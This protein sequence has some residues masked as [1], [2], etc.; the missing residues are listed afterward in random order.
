[1]EIRKIQ[2]TDGPGL[3]KF[4]E[5]SGTHFHQIDPLF[6]YHGVESDIVAEILRYAGEV[7]VALE[8]G[9]IIGLLTAK[10]RDWDTKHF[11]YSVASIDHFYTKDQQ[12]AESLLTEFSNWANQEKIAFSSIKTFFKS[13]ITAAL[14]KSG[15]YFVEE[16]SYLSKKLP[17]EKLATIEG[18]F[19]AGFKLRDFEPSDLDEL[20]R[21]VQATEWSNRFHNDS[22]IDKTKANEVYT[23]W[24]KNGVAKQNTRV[25]ILEGN[26]KIAGFILWSIS[27]M[28]LAASAKATAAEVGDQE[29]VAMAPEFRGQGLGKFL[30]GGCVKQMQEAGCVLVW[31]VVASQNLAAIKNLE[32]LGFTAPYKVSAYHWFRK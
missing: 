8:L 19:P 4:L 24:V 23:N 12:I 28:G 9:K 22:K 5:K 15:F 25:T 29:M 27:K 10:K 13:E 31:T 17:D 21:I 16:D 7:W 6:R 30:Y 2:L 32:K 18:E 1:M 14:E 11:G 26:G 3:E 20:L